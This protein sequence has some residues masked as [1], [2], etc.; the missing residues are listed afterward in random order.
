[1]TMNR[2]AVL[3]NTLCFYVEDGYPVPFHWQGTPE[4]LM[5]L[6][7]QNFY[8]DEDVAFQAAH[9]D[10]KKVEYDLHAILDKLK[11]AHA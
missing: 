4:Q 6:D 1:M 11:I 7:T 8:L 3:M 5:L 10:E 2:P 9:F